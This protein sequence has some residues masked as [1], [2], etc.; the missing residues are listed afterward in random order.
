MSEPSYNS[1][2][3]LLLSIA[4]GYLSFRNNHDSLLFDNEYKFCTFVCSVGGLTCR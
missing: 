4:V 1:L 3:I 2:S